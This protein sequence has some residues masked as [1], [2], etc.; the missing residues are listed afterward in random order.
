MKENPEILCS[1]CHEPIYRDDGSCTN[2]FI[3][4]CDKLLYETNE[5]IEKC[6]EDMA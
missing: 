4:E 6:N 5:I 3:E 1:K 2:C